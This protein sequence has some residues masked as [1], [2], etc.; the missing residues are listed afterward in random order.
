MEPHG[1]QAAELDGFLEPVGHK[2]GVP[3][4]SVGSD[5]EQAGVGPFVARLLLPLGAFVEVGAEDVDGGGAEGRC[6]LRLR[7]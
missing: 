1:W 6:G 2:V 4:V 7:S 3:G 5:E